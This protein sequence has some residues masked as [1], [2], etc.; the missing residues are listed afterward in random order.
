MDDDYVKTA[1]HNFTPQEL[2]DRNVAQRDFSIDLDGGDEG[3][4]R[5]HGKVT[6]TGVGEVNTWV[7][8]LTELECVRESKVDQ[9]TA[10]D[11]PYILLSIQPLPGEPISWR[12]EPYKDVD[13]GERVAINYRSPDIKVHAAEG[14]LNIAVCV[15]EQDDQATGSA[16]TS[17]PIHRQNEGEAAIRLHGLGPQTERRANRRLATRRADGHGLEPLGQ[18][19]RG[20]PVNAP[21]QWIKASKT[22]YFPLS[23]AGYARQASLWTTCCPTGPTSRAARAATDPRPRVLPL[24][25]LP[26]LAL[27][28][29][30][31][32]HVAVAG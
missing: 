27:P 6:R 17:S 5:V 26:P 4:Y 32:R 7:V 11:E 29:R 9:F 12:N 22:E 1:A 30:Q 8:Q 2:N 10:S 19:A 23:S 28:R 20:S 25:V 31:L 3:F 21:W 16:T 14:I 15:M 18:P 13:K 24:R